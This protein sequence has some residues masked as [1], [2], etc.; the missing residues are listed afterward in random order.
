MT[1]SG[2]QKH[3]Q[4]QFPSQ[5]VH[6]PNEELLWVS[7][8]SLFLFTSLAFV[9]PFFACNIFPKSRWGK[10]EG[11][12]T[13]KDFRSRVKPEAWTFAEPVKGLRA[14]GKATAT[15]GTS[16]TLTTAT[17]KEAAQR[18]I[19]GVGWRWEQRGVMGEVGNGCVGDFFFP[20]RGFSMIL[21][22]RIDCLGCNAMQQTAKQPEQW[23]LNL[24]A[25]V[26]ERAHKRPRGPWK[27]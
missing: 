24:Y 18:G 16:A 26:D 2:I 19:E 5:R 27:M 22:L 21:C 10:D 9:F 15:R 20:A 1:A 4:L 11:L 14:E 23:H 17:A 12:F 3:L 13:C 25:E 6:H 7:A 8:F